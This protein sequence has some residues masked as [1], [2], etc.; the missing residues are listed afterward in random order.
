VYLQFAR[1]CS[2]WGTA[3]AVSDLFGVPVWAGTV[4]GFGAW[5]AAGLGGFLARVTDLLR[6]APVAGFDEAS[7]RVAGGNWWVCGAP[8]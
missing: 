7:M 6:V 8:G 5:A 3:Q 1:F 2:R 4:S